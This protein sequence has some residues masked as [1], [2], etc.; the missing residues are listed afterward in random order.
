M[1]DFSK[2][3][4]HPA[5]QEIVDTLCK[6]TMNT[7][8]SFYQAQ[9]AYFLG[10]MAA[11]MGVTVLTKD[12]GPVPVNIYSIGVATSGFGKGHSVAIMEE[13]VMNG[14]KRRFMDDTFNYLA[15]QNLMKIA[16]RRAVRDG[17][18]QQEEFE[19]AQKEFRSA[20]HHLYTFSEGTSPAVKQLR[21]KLLLSGAGAINLQIDE[22]GSNLVANTEVLNVFLELYDQGRIKGKLIKESADNK[23]TEEIDGKTPT[24][25]LLF[26]SPDRIFDGSQTEDQF[27]QFLKIGYA[28]R[29][30]FGFGEPNRKAY[31]SKTP[32]EIYADLTTKQNSATLDAWNDHFENLA[33]PALF[34][35]QIQL[36]DPVAIELLRYKIDCERAADAL[37]T[38]KDTEKAELSHRYYKALKLAGAYAFIDQSSTLEL[39][40]LYSAIKVVE[41]SG[42]A[43]AE[44]IVK[45]EPAYA[46]LARFIAGCDRE[47]THADLH[48][49][50]PFYK[51]GQSARSEM[52]TLAQAYGYKQH[53][54]LKKR[55]IDGIEFF[56]GET[57]KETSL[58]K[59]RIAYSDNFAYNYEGELAPFDQLHVLTQAPGLHWIN[60]WAEGGHR[61]EDKII[62]GFNLV[63]I[64]IDG[65]VTLDTVHELMKDYTF[66]TYTTK[67][68]TDEE[69]RFRLIMPI[70][71]TLELDSEDY[72]EFMNSFMAWLPFDSDAAANQRSK[73]W[74]SFEGGTHHYNEGQMVDALPFIPRTNKNEQFLQANK[75]LQSLDNLERWFAQRMA[76]GNRNNHMIK[77]AL[78]LMDGG[79]QLTEVS[80][81]VHT[82]NKKLKE[83]LPKAE[84]DST[85]LVTVAKRFVEREA[86]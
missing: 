77:F 25:M 72:K 52:I 1:M 65:G 43:F 68:H 78:A 83:P 62:P 54:I 67:R 40:H 14:F 34:G 33:D 3:P 36:E 44:K 69:N 85:V 32:E 23:R 10:M 38:H 53:I 81:R 84:I 19:K 7:D 73:K 49:E 56:S 20:G 46:K 70:N 76:S 29:C 39:D 37:D 55:F 80:N 51:T 41:E 16:N 58:D 15:E 66:M 61:A 27:Y 9:V 75:E 64:D 18:D 59:L 5:M 30:I 12:R 6:Q 13:Q 31:Y 17:T 8:R 79:M 28:R 11:N 63:V 26:G 42:Q 50:L 86:A 21:H 22:I 4:H 2:V 57:L 45:R 71:Y 60:H 48:E 24:N 82:F 35:W 74:Q 47:L